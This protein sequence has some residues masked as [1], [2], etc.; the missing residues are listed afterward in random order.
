[1]I[2]DDFDACFVD[3]LG[4]TDLFI[5]ELNLL[6]SSML[7]FTRFGEVIGELSVNLFSFMLETPDVAVAIAPICLESC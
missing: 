6:P 4:E 7:M 5:V 3:G 2:N 1:M